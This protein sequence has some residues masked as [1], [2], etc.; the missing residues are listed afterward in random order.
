MGITDSSNQIDPAD[1]K[2]VDFSIK[3]FCLNK[4]SSDLP[5]SKAG[6]IRI[7]L[8]LNRNFIVLYGA[9]A[10]A[11]SSYMLNDIRLSFMS[12]PEPQRK[13]PVYLRTLFNMKQLVRSGLANV[14][15]KIPA[16]CNAV[17]CSFQRQSRENTMYYTNFAITRQRPHE[18]CHVLTVKSR[19]CDPVDPIFVMVGFVVAGAVSE[20]SRVMGGDPGHIGAWCR[21]VRPL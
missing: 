12:V 20:A 3:E 14:S 6:A 15:S 2:P 10:V 13:A 21:R 17:S 8:K 16:V 5:Y 9:N 18:L 7:S 4:M 11:N 19:T 1:S